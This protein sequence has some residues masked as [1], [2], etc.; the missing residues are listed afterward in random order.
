LIGGEDAHLHRLLS[1]VLAESGIELG[2]GS[3]PPDIVL[4][5]VEGSGSEALSAL[6]SQARRV[7][8]SSPIV[9]LLPIGDDRL[10]KRS[11][12]LGAHGCWS[13]DTPLSLL[14][15]LISTLLPELV[16]E[17]GATQRGGAVADERTFRLG[18]ASR[19]LIELLRAQN[20]PGIYPRPT[21]EADAEERIER[22]VRQDLAWQRMN[23]RQ[24]PDSFRFGVHARLEVTLMRLDA[25]AASQI[26]RAIQTDLDAGIGAKPVEQA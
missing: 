14:R 4:A 22:A 18:P 10:A 21:V 16:K 6:L 20:P 26:E 13:L 24:V 25:Q 1:D 19:A 8:G 3:K 7:A 17:A 2:A 12:Q 15:S 9:A 23:S 5:V 11:I